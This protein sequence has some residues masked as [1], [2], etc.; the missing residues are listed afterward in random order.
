M[1]GN[2]LLLP[3]KV[4]DAISSGNLTEAESW[5]FIIAMVDYDRNGAL[6]EFPRGEAGALWSMIKPEMDYNKKSWQ[7]E[8][9][10][11]SEAGKKGGASRSEAKQ[12]AARE[13]GQAGGR[14]KNTETE[15]PVGFSDTKP[16]ETETPVGLNSENSEAEIT[17]AEYEYVNESDNVYGNVNDST[18]QN[19]FENPNILI[20]QN[21]AKSLGFTITAKQAS[22]FEDCLDPSWLEGSDNFLVFAAEEIRRKEK[23]KTPDDHIRLF[24]K[25]WSFENFLED[26][27]GWFQERHGRQGKKHS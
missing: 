5:Q 17:Q 4:I 15:T 20:I 25:S 11:R 19:I 8:L 21:I 14:P 13:N 3:Y 16:T 27:P 10:R 6:P 1:A 7:E 9:V 12:A 18:I 2:H 22:C 24:V 26:Y 23:N